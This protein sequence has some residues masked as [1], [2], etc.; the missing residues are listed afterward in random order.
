[1]VLVIALLGGES[2]GKSTLAADLK[3]ALTKK[4]I[5][6]AL[7]TENLRTWCATQG[8]APSQSDQARLAGEQGHQVDAAVRS[9]PPVQ[10]VIADTTPLM[11][12]AYSELYFQDTSLYPA[13]LAWQRHA[14]L[15]LLMGLDVP[16]VPDGLFRDGPALRE[17]TDEVLR[18][19][20]QTADLPFHT[21][22]GL[23]PARLQAALRI[24]E[25]A[26]K[27]PL[28][29]KQPSIESA[30]AAWSCERCSDP[31]CERRLF[32]RLL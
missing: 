29:P 5:A 14:D 17:R 6:T 24:V 11:I 1:M 23:G 9:E 10:V 30:A 8:R 27:P 18:H 12:A 2:T 25:Q 26:L 22:Y 20:L 3:T 21:V 16:W 32:S 28:S 7:V 13:A 31:E 4:G 19:Q 15:H